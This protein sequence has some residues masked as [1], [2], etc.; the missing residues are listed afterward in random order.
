MSQIQ[1]SEPQISAI[2]FKEKERR[3]EKKEKEISRR[4]CSNPPHPPRI[5]LFHGRFILCRAPPFSEALSSTHAQPWFLLP[6]LLPPSVFLP[7]HRAL[8]RVPWLLLGRA[9]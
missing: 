2:I 4:P 3:N 8:G 5:F 1:I 6:Y 9:P 7:G